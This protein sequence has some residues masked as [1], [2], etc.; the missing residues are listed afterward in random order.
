MLEQSLLEQKNNNYLE[1]PLTEMCS[2]LRE[3]SKS[4]N[5]HVHSCSQPNGF[6]ILT[7]G[8][9][10][11]MDSLMFFT[12]RIDPQ[13]LNDTQ[14]LDTLRYSAYDYGN[15]SVVILVIPEHPDYSYSSVASETE[16]ASQVHSK[17]KKYLEKNIFDHN[18]FKKA[19]IESL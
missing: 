19:L 17:S 2:L 11:K 18:L 9:I 13:R 5:I 6:K 1:L 12:S 8:L 10:T 3:K 14:L 7:E 4:S 16:N 15:D